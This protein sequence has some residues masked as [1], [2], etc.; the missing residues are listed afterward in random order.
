[1]LPLIERPE[2]VQDV[3]GKTCLARRAC[4]HRINRHLEG[5]CV[6]YAALPIDRYDPSQVA[7]L[8]FPGGAPW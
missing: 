5:R 3:L 2:T 6:S 1:M 4:G 8:I 7:A